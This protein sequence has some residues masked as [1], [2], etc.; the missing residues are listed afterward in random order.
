VALV[1]LLGVVDA[2]FY[3]I[4]GLFYCLCLVVGP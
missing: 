2:F 3:C 1:E 4:L